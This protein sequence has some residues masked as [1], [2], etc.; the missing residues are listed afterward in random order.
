VK[1]MRPAY[2]A[3][4]EATNSDARQA[5]CEKPAIRMRSRVMPADSI[6]STTEATF[7]SAELRYGSLASRGARNEFGYQVCPAPCGARY[8]R[9]SR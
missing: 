9:P 3:G 6:S 4:F 5:P 7:A 8:A 2:R 1:A